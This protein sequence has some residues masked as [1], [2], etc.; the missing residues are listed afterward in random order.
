MDTTSNQPR[1]VQVDRILCP[2]DFDPLS[3]K[4]AQ[5]AAAFA[6][7][8]QAQLVLLHVQPAPTVVMPMGGMAPAISLSSE[9]DR[10]AAID[11]E[12][13]NDELELLAG[14]LGTDLEIEL[15]VVRGNG[16][17]ARSILEVAEETPTQ[18]IVIGSHGRSGFSRFFMGSIA[19]EVMRG[20][21]QPVL[22]VPDSEAA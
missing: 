21:T 10:V 18:L 2:V 5:R 11:R 13:S 15:E 4:A 12:V 8:L 1:S 9:R 19:E 16:S 6:R 14:A 22:V 17:V 3:R 20:A 7:Q